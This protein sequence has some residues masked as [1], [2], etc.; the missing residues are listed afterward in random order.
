MSGG[1]AGFIETVEKWL[2]RG[3]VG[4]NKVRLVKGYKL[5]IRR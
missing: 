2:S 4:R 3:V 5:S 1:G